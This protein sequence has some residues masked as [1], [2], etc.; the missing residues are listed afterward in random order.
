MFSLA[1]RQIGMRIELTLGDIVFSETDRW[2]RRTHAGTEA[3]TP[4]FACER[5]SRAKTELL[6]SGL[7]LVGVLHLRDPRSYHFF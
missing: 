1:A 4:H 6:R 3:S 5:L 2:T 7:T